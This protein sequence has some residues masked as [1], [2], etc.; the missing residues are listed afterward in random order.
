MI[1]SHTDTE[2]WPFF[3]VREAA[4]GRVLAI[5]EAQDIDRASDFFDAIRHL[6]SVNGPVQFELY[7]GDSLPTDTPTFGRTYYRAL[8]TM[9]NKEAA[10]RRAAGESEMLRH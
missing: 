1:I 9:A 10:S 7:S 5:V 3:A 2:V 6:Y 8:Q 4:T